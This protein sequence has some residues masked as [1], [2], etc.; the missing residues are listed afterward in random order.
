MVFAAA[1]SLGGQCRHRAAHEA[2]EQGTARF[3]ARF[4]AN[5]QQHRHRNHRPNGLPHRAIQKRCNVKFHRVTEHQNI[6]GARQQPEHTEASLGHF[7]TDEEGEN[8]QH[9]TQQEQTLLR[10]GHDQHKHHRSHRN[11]QQ[12]TDDEIHRHPFW[13]RG[14]HR[15]RGH[16]GDDNHAA[17]GRGPAGPQPHQAADSGGSER[18]QTVDHRMMALCRHRAHHYFAIE[19][20][21]F[22]GADTA[23][24]LDAF[25]QQQRAGARTGPG[26]QGHQ[27]VIAV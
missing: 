19:H 13:V 25:H 26:A 27:D 7:D 6:D 24:G 4:I 2:V 23:V 16:D 18:S 3:F 10:G 5:N 8:P 22:N 20:A 14:T 15:Q 11:S 17:A 12:H 9:Q 1:I 21:A